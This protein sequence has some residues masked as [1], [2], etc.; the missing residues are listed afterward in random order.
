MAKVKLPG[1][2]ATQLFILTAQGQAPTDMPTLEGVLALRETLRAA[3]IDQRRAK[4]EA[5]VKEGHDALAADWEDKL[6]AF[7]KTHEV[8][9]ELQPHVKVVALRLIAGPALQSPAAFAS[10]WLRLH[11][12]LGG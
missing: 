4:L 9:V 3:G 8:V 2:G 10:A 6:A 11:K 5:F 7:D 1:F 12:A